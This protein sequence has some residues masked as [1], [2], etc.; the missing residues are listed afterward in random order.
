MEDFVFDVKDL[1][2]DEEADKLFEE[3]EA[4]EGQ[5]ETEPDESKHAEEEQEEE[6]PSEKVGVEDDKPEENAI[7]DEGD[8]SS[9]NV[10]SSIASA[11]RDDGIF[12]GSSDEDIKGVTTPEAFAELFEKEITSRLDERQKRIDSALGNGMAPDKVR[13][14]EQTIQY[15]D[16]ITEENLSAEG[17]EGENLR[18]Q[19]IYNDLVNRGYSQ[20]KAIKKMD[21]SFA[22]GNDIDDA[23][24]A[25]ET[26]T[27]YYKA[28]YE[29]E[30]KEAKHHAEEIRNNQK[31]QAE[32]LRKMIL[33]DEV[34]LGDTKLDKRTCQRV[35]DAISK[36]VYKDPDS[37]Q[38][39]TAIQKFQKE[40]PLEFLRQI[41]MWYIL[42][43]GGKDTKGFTK[44]QVRAAKNESIKELGRKINA[45][46]LNRD[47]TLKYSSRETGGS[48]DPLL[49]DDWKIG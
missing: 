4:D 43:D 13:M 46:A 27:K 10:Y 38:L 17:E 21:Q 39:L 47:G 33:E 1:L 41:G 26:L 22:A 29:N 5:P 44:E 11:L 12:S 18:K 30:Q 37:G 23:K 19:L 14:Y 28:G 2:S 24:D 31:K 16:G 9:P 15:L 32:N 40:N 42:T 34:K 35:Y 20:E 49:S 25:L 7:V 45:T 3:Q 36:P 6:A 48:L 8:G